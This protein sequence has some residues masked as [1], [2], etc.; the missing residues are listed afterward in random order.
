MSLTNYAKNKVQ[1]HLFGSVSFTPSGSYYLAL[2]TTTISSSGSNMTEPA[3]AVGYARQPIPNDKL[4]GFSFS[5]SGCLV[6]YSTIT[7]PISTGSWGTITDVALVDT[8]T[9]GSVWAYTTLTTPK[10]IQADTTI[11]FSASAISISLT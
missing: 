11:T 8:L 1:D 7:Y 10:I 3:G 2:S 6:N 4:T 9:S 5:S